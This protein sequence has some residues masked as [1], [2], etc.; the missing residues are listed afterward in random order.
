[1]LKLL[2]DGPDGHQS[3]KKRRE[4]PDLT[5]GKAGFEGYL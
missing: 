2:S 5:S 4:G 1:M 3:Q